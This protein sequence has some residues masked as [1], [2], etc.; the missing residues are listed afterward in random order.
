MCSK[1][2]F[3]IVYKLLRAN[4]LEEALNKIYD[5]EEDKL[6]SPF[7]S[8]P[9]HA[10]YVVGDIFFEFGQFD[11]AENAFEK[12]LS[13]R[14]DDKQA[15]MALANAQMECN[16]ADNAETTLLRALSLDPT[17]EN[18]IYNLGNALFDQGKYSEAIN[19]YEKIGDERVK[20]KADA[21]KN[22]LLAR[23]KLATSNGTLT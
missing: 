7:D 18:Y 2:V 13:H 12:A 19:E 20:L 11:Y 5:Q 8:D 17:N 1:D 23:K 14:E 21:I 4:L 16:R 3:E 9:N 10:W 6:F 22:S 15:L